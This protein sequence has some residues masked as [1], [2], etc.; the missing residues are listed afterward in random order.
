MPIDAESLYARAQRS[1][2]QPAPELSTAEALFARAQS[3]KAKQAAFGMVGGV[4]PMTSGQ[5]AFGRAFVE[6]F[7]DNVA[8]IPDAVLT[9]GANAAAK[10]TPTTT[11]TRA[12]V[13]PD[14]VQM[15]IQGAGH[16]AK[17]MSFGQS[18][19]F[20]AGDNLR[21]G[22]PPVGSRVLG[23][24]RGSE[25]V[26]GAL[27]ALPGGKGSLGDQYNEQM[28]RSAELLRQHPGMAK[29][30]EVL[31]DAATVAT[32]RMP[33]AKATVRAEKAIASA[34]PRINMPPGLRRQMNEIWFSDAMK[35]LKR[36][37]GRAAETSLEGATLAILQDG[38]PL[39]TAMLSGGMQMGASTTL[40]ILGA[41][42]PG[43][44]GVFKGLALP[45]RIGIAAAGA[46]AMYNVLTNFTPL[47]Q[48]NIF[49]TLEADSAAYAKVSYALG[50]G[51]LAGMVGGRMRSGSLSENL[52]WI[53]EALTAIPRGSMISV[54]KDLAA[55]KETGK[56]DVQRALLHLST[57]PNVFNK[58]QITQ[59]NAAFESGKFGE[60][61]E[62]M[63]QKDPR[64]AKIIDASPPDAAFAVEQER[65]EKKL[66]DKLPEPNKPAPASKTSGTRKNPKKVTSQDDY[67]ALKSGEWFE[68]ED[69]VGQK[70]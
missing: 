34:A 39:E 24:P 56:L 70:P 66:L 64:F 12:S 6:R 3:S 29:T 49:D 61:V 43:K 60:T 1:R 65:R 67:D 36:G 59:L 57:N 4:Q 40:G 50:A 16:L 20:V 8:G 33:L 48:G 30:G 45:Y 52:P 53:P 25:I 58:S 13:I 46:S 55:E 15:A 47:G 9:M 23:L 22:V 62:A 41:T 54:M 17:A 44:T 2:T 21:A 37:A 35:S 5:N 11:P 10:L 69:G 7:A 68:D 38:D 26:A 31:A 42:I 19:P 32:G 18:D 28:V 63:A 51:L 14:P 27:A